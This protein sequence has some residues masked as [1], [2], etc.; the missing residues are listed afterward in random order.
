MIKKKGSPSVP[1]L[2]FVQYVTRSNGVIT[3]VERDLVEDIYL[4][5]RVRRW[6]ERTAEEVTGGSGRETSDSRWRRLEAQV[7]QKVQVMQASGREVQEE[8]D[9]WRRWRKQEIRFAGDK[10]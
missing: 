4:L 6:Q 9:H 5:Y 7:R 3:D 1:L 2:V 8:S 10:K